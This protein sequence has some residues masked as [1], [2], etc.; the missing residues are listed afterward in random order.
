VTLPQ[1]TPDVKQESSQGEMTPD[2]LALP[3]LSLAEQ[4]KEDVLYSLVADGV[5]RAFA[6]AGAD[7]KRNPPRL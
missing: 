5:K 4:A 7:I 2:P 3:G 1:T 6:P